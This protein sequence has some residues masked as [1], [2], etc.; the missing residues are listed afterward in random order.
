MNI[1]LPEAVHMCELRT[2]PQDNPDYH[3]IR[4]EMWRKI[5]EV[6]PALAQAGKFIDWEKYRLGRLQAEMRTEFK[7]SVYE[8]ERIN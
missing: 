6:H 5:Q 2:T 1:A 4:E 7:K 3:F 8:K